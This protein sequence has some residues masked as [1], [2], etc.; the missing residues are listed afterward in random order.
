MQSYI[1]RQTQPSGLKKL[2]GCQDHL[3]PLVSV[4]CVE[5]EPAKLSAGMAFDMPLARK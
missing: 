1:V 5:Q 3:T 4:E 2:K